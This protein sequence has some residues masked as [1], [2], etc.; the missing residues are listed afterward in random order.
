MAA[1]PGLTVERNHPVNRRNVLQGLL[2]FAFGLLAP[3]RAKAAEPDNLRR[4]YRWSRHHGWERVRMIQLRKGDLFIYEIGEGQPEKGIT[5]S[6]LYCRASV[7]PTRLPPPNHA[8]IDADTNLSEGDM[9]AEA[10]YT[11]LPA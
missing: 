9:P 11:P 3:W 1:G 7:D 8:H 6:W 4:I 2:A 10:F 5:L